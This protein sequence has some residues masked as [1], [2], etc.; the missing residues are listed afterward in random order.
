MPNRRLRLTS[1]IVFV[2]VLAAGTLLWLNRWNIYDASRMR[3]YQ[4][5]TAVAQLATDTTMNDKTR[6]LFYVNHPDLEN[7][8]AFVQSC[9]SAEKTIVLGCYVPA[10]GIYLSDITDPRLAGVVQVTAAHETL[11]AAYDRLSTSEKRNVDAMLNQAYDQVTDKRVRDTIDAYRKEGADISNELHSILGTEVRD[12]P[13]TLESYYARYFKDRKAVVAYS[14]KY[15]QAFTERQKSVE[16][17][18]Q[19]LTDLK[20]QIDAAES[21]LSGQEAQLRTDRTRLDGLL[22]AK[23]FDA[24]NAD[25]PRYN[26]QVNSYNANVRRIRTLIDGY[27][28]VVN[29]RNAVAL[30]ESEL[31]KAIDSRPD[32]LNTQQ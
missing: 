31:V 17:F 2:F 24:Y 18:D 4:A 20:K 10:Q 6:R 27:N 30:E 13:P 19:Q 32:T 12:L 5:P 16:N 22:A 29:Q 11:H 8:A 26:A 25:V 7:K 9:K 1:L 14:E 15:E 3:G 23:Q 21:A 28:K